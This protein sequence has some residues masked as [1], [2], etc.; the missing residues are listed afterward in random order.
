MSDHCPV[1]LQ[2]HMCS[3][4]AQRRLLVS[5]KR[6]SHEQ[7]ASHHAGHTPTMMLRTIS[8]DWFSLVEVSVHLL[9]KACSEWSTQRVRSHAATRILPLKISLHHSYRHLRRSMQR[10]SGSYERRIE[11]Q[12]DVHASE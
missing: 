1:Q 2:F 8:L 6:N 4:P 12:Q 11:T 7:G 9:G 10:K 3:R 5:L